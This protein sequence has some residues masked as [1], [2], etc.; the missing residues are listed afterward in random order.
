MTYLEWFESHATKHH[1]VVSKLLKKKYTKQMI[2]SY[3]H[4]ENMVEKEPDFCHLYKEQKKCHE[5]ENLNCYLCACPNF[6][7]NDNGIKNTN[8][9]T[10]YSFCSIASKDGKEFHFQNAIHQDCS[11]CNIPHNEKYILDH[12]DTLWNAIMQNCK[13]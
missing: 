12:F 3:F 9:K 8:D 2:V 11:G 10:L 4:F 6:R 13:I 5:I 7:F 1:A